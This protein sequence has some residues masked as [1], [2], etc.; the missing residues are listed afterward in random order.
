MPLTQLNADL[1]K[2]LNYYLKEVK[3]MYPAKDKSPVTN[4]D[5]NELARETYFTLTSFKDQIIE[6]LKTH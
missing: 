2:T 5:I 1:E 4:E 6:Y 3:L